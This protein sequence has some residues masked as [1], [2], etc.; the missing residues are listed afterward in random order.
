[1]FRRPFI[2]AAESRHR[3]LQALMAGIVLAG[4]AL[5]IW[6]LDY[7]QGMG[8]HPDERSNSYYAITIRMPQD[9]NNLLHPRLSPLNPFWDTGLNRA[10]HF[11][12]GHFPLYLGVLA[13]WTAHNAAPL[14]DAL[15]LPDQWIKVASEAQTNPLSFLLIGR[16]VVMLLDSLTVWLVLLIGRRL[17]GIQAGFLAA[18]L[19][20]IAVMPFKDS[21]FFTVDIAITTFV[22]LTLLGYLVMLER[23]GS[24]YGVGLTGLG[25]G[26]SVAS[27]FSA[28]PII[29]LFGG[30]F[31]L[32]WQRRS[33]TVTVR[34]LG[35]NWLLQFLATIFIATLTFAVASPFV[36]TDWEIFRFSVLEQQGNMVTGNNDWPFTRQYRGTLPYLYYIQQQLQWGLWYP[37]GITVLA[38]TLW[39][40]L[41]VGSSFWKQPPTWLPRLLDGECLIMLWVLLYFGPT[42]AFLAKFNRYVL[43]ILPAVILLGT[44]LIAWLVGWRKAILGDQQESSGKTGNHQPGIL[45]RRFGLFWCSVVVAGS[46]FWLGTNI[47]GIYERNH[48][49]HDASRWI[50]ENVPDGS[51]ILWEQWDDPLPKSWQL[52]ESQNPF[53][54]RKEFH[55]IDWNPFAEEDQQKWQSLKEFLLASDYLVFSSRRTLGA[56]PRLPQRYPLTNRYYELLFNGELG[57]EVVH[58]ETRHPSA[59]GLQFDDTQADESWRLYDHP[60]VTILA[61]V[62]ALSDQE[63]DELL[64]GYTE[65]SKNWYVPSSPFPT[66]TLAQFSRAEIRATSD[67]GTIWRSFKSV[68]GK[69]GTLVFGRSRFD[70]LDYPLNSNWPLDQFRFN[71][72]GSTRAWA[73]VLI[74]WSGIVLMGIVVWPFCFSLFA[75]LPD[76]GYALTKGLGWLGLAL[77]TWWIAHLGLPG[78]TA[79][80]IWLTFLAVGTVSAYLGW[81]QRHDFAKKLRDRWKLLL[82]EETG[83][84]LAYLLFVCI[85]LLNP[86]LWHPWTGG[87]KFMDLAILNGILRSPEF[88]PIDSHFA[89][90]F[91]NYYYWGHYLVAYLM[92]MTGLWVEVAFNLA[93]ASFFAQVVL[94]SWSCSFYFHMRS[95]GSRGEGYRQSSSSGAAWPVNLIRALWAPFLLIGIGNLEGAGQ[96]L[97]S[98]K[99]MVQREYSGWPSILGEPAQILLG[100]WDTGLVGSMLNYDFWG[101]SRVIPN[102]INEFPY[103]TFLFGDL[104]AHLLV[105]PITLL[106]LCSIVFGYFY[107]EDLKKLIALLA[108]MAVIASIGIATNLWELPLYSLLILFFLVSLSL[109]HLSRRKAL[110]VGVASFAVL[111][112]GLLVL[113]PFWRHFDVLATDGLGWVKRGDAPSQWL[114]IWGLFYPII[115][116]WLSIGLY[117]S[118]SGQAPTTV[119]SEIGILGICV[120]L[121]LLPCLLWQ[122]L[123]LALATLPLLLTGFL[124]WQKRESSE[125]G[126]VVILGWLLLVTGIW[127][128]TQVLYVKDFLSGGEAY[129]MNTLFKFFLQ[130]W[131]LAAVAVAILLPNLWSK[132]RALNFPLFTWASGCGFVILLAASLVYPA[133]GTPARLSQRFPDE[134]PPLGTL[135]GL[136]YMEGGSYNWPNQNHEIFLTFDR[137]AIDWLNAHIKTNLVILESYVLDYYRAAGT[138][139]SSHTGLPGLLGMHQSEQRDANSVSKRS[140][141]MYSI[142]N[143]STPQ[144]M[145]KLLEANSVGLIYAGQLEQIEH[146]QGVRHLTELAASNRLVLIY[147]NP[148]T[149]IYALP[150]R[151]AHAAQ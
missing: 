142:W 104:H 129:R 36:L 52:L 94:L 31:L 132:I 118:W 7:D 90:R 111:L 121:L 42:G 131:V 41:R 2:R 19:W 91:L 137:D 63:F 58:Q 55:K 46:V 44:G 144:E 53:I 9:A 113:F 74:W 133:L 6:H 59:F 65:T 49:W 88:P 33:A 147:D 40:L 12:Y 76:A 61:K 28:L 116:T 32:Q 89:G 4:L 114:R 107:I 34:L 145:L 22:T 20:S 13:A 47:N 109:K 84:A 140:G 26:L 78:F 149:R 106:L 95:A 130:A 5:R 25:L 103:W 56:I 14:L 73:S 85:R 27:K 75:R 101:P 60:P 69:L 18:F 128:G 80:G 45:E 24:L 151:M 82:W 143:A 39:A 124:L 68:T 120:I 8:S 97:S 123:T 141:V 1:M 150:N 35:L 72:F 48:T 117:S 108:L 134:V 98:A 100:V 15:G 29:F 54:P 43:P 148:K 83:F 138:R 139:I 92:K 57:F 105:M 135:N 110:T 93:L 51:V 87:E 127:T 30:L 37:L 23:P 21:H 102:T 79:A 70:E 112:V 67:L 38:G 50:Y 62:N 99:L 16:L 119:K 146:P 64:L 11:T 122:R 96:W 86:D 125:R 10:R 115:L 66:S 3:F 17:Y 81:R 126:E 77:I 136:D 71:E